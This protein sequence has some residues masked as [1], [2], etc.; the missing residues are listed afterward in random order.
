ML[1]PDHLFLPSPLAP[2]AFWPLFADKSRGWLAERCV[3]PRDCVVLLPFIELVPLARQAFAAIEGWQPRVETAQTLALA[4]GPPGAQGD[5]NAPGVSGDP[6]LDSLAVAAMLRSQPGLAEWQDRDPEAFDQAVA[7]VLMA[8]QT[9]VRGVAAVD[10]QARGPWWAEAREATAR[11]C[12]GSAMA[13]L[14]S[15]LALEW[16]ALSPAPDT[17][18]LLDYPASAWLVLDAADRDPLCGLLLERAARQGVP[19]LRL[20]ADAELENAF[21]APLSVPPTL[22]LCQDAEQE[23]WAAAGAVIELVAAGHAPVALIAEDRLQVRRIRALLDRA[24]LALADETGWTLDTTHAGAH[25]MVMLR[26]ATPGAGADA[27]LD[28]L[29][30]AFTGPDATWVDTLERHWRRGAPASPGSAM[31]ERLVHAQQRWQ[32]QQARLVE[33]RG[34]GHGP[35][36]RWLQGLRRML[37]GAPA[38]SGADADA[39][40]DNHS[41]GSSDDAS[42]DPT[43][44]AAPSATWW[45]RD[46]AGRQVWQCLRLGDGLARSDLDDLPLTL[47]QF[48]RWVDTVLRQGSF[49]PAAL[50]PQVVI[51]P[52]ARAMLRPFAAVVLPGADDQHLAPPPVN[53]GLLPQALLRHLGLPDVTAVGKRAERAFVQL[54]RHP[55]LLML[56]R[57]LDGDAPLADSPWWSR[58]AMARLRQGLAAAPVLAPALRWR[59]LTAAPVLRPAPVAPQ[60]LP[61]VV[62]ASAVEA[63]RACPYRFFARSVL[64][65]GEDEELEADPGKRE[66]GTLMHNALHQFHEDRSKRAD[67]QPDS[68]A[69]AAQRLLD[70]AEAAMVEAGL[71]AA[72]M[73]P[74]MVGLPAF[75]QRYLPWLAEREAAGWSY[76]AGELPAEVAPKGLGGLRLRG[77]IDRIDLRRSKGALTWQLLDYKTGAVAGLKDKLKDPLEDTQLAFYAAQLITGGLAQLALPPEAQLQAA[78]VALDERAGMAWLPHPEVAVSAQ[79]LLDGLAEDWSRLSAGAPMRA[80]GEE[81]V[82][83]HCEARGLCRR[84]H[85]WNSDGA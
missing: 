21:E 16:A 51:T 5:A 19:S 70:F 67:A 34:A 12:A 76:L 47:A 6:A 28:W 58:L 81:P 1:Q 14:L 77:R 40:A 65:L 7:T 36:G 73:L 22:W 83:G 42:G 63:L 59:A 68:D 49:R 79:A 11:F 80:L 82:C 71:D 10:P 9:L 35:L 32:R 26:A 69:L 46:D 39:D 64:G 75:A 60:A 33:F 57:Q 38:G 45:Q 15:Q 3:A 18:R 54:L 23:A 84:D 44:A 50:N 4:L 61:K 52:L 31:P 43:R 55:R 20:S 17:D 2:S 13:G 8:A 74:F 41:G 30:C 27:W 48:T 66:F 78:Y 53:S 62:S 85:W 24:G 25:V 37:E 56:R 29:K 72:A